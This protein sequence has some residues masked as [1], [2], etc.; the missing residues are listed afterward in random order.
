MA[1]HLALAE[2]EDGL[3]EIRRAPKD[4]GVLRAIVIRPQTDT[5]IS[6]PQC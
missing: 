2:L 6:L 4:R 5:R 3:S 1:R